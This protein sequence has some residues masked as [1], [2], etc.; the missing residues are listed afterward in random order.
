M[1]EAIAPFDVLTTVEAI[2]T[3]INTLSEYR[4]QIDV[5]ELQKQELKD[6]ILT[7]DLLAELR[8]IDIEFEER[9]K[10]ARI[11]IAELTTLIKDAVVAHGKTVKGDYLM[12]VR[13]KGRVSWNTKK[14][15]GF[16]VAYPALLELRKEGKPSVTIRKR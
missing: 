3:S 5:L 8:D 4:S 16:A 6:A 10:V 11:R 13:N 7:D 12:A 2:T 14:L 1:T 9:E 15:D